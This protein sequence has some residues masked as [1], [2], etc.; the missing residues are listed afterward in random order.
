MTNE[1]ANDPQPVNNRWMSGSDLEAR[2][3]SLSTINAIADTVYRFL[4]LN[5]LVEHA[6]DV[7]LEYIPVSSVALFTL[8]VSGK[9]LNMAAWRG[10]TEDTVKVGSRLPLTG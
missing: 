1:L 3:S 5:T 2:A 6:V 8:D 7:I 10:F 4:D 9:W